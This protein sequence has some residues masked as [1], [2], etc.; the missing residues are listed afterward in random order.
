MREKKNNGTRREKLVEVE[1]RNSRDG[2]FGQAEDMEVIRTGTWSHMSP[3]LQRQ[4]Q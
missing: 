2:R 1:G 3:H 4:L